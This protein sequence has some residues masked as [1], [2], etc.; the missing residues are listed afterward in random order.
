[1]KQWLTDTWNR[2]FPW[3]PKKAKSH[4]FIP[5][6]P[7]RSF[8]LRQP[9]LAQRLRLSRRCRRWQRR[10]RRWTVTRSRSWT[11]SRWSTCR[12][13]WRSRLRRPS[14]LWTICY[15]CQDLKLNYSKSKS[16]STDVVDHCQFLSVVVA[17]TS[18]CQ[19]H[20]ST[21]ELSSSSLSYVFKPEVWQ[22]PMT[23]RLVPLH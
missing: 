4:D 12:S 6:L 10:R 23:L 5:I 15:Y 18:I 3:Q 9:H 21:S 19:F 22:T 17:V 16:W 20:K 7:P 13:L 14:K 1:M 2:N 8:L 11:R